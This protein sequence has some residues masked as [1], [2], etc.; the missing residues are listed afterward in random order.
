MAIAGTF[1][2]F[3]VL[4]S[5]MLRAMGS[6]NVPFKIFLVEG[7]FVLG[8]LL[9]VA[10]SG[11]EAVALAMTII[12]S[13]TACTIIGLTC[14]ILGIG[15]WKLGETLVPGITLAASAALPILSLRLLGLNLL[16]GALEPLILIAASSVAVLIVLA[17]VYRGLVK[18]VI[19][20]V[21]SPKQR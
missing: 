12:L 11:I 4:S 7:L 8:A 3:S 9:L 21:N 10:A 1:R 13:L 17:T 6:P 19:A 14:R 20:L 2:V 18:E 16:P 15:L 5:D